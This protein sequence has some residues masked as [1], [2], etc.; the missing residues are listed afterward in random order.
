MLCACVCLGFGFCFTSPILARVCGVCFW[1][2]GFLLAAQWLEC[3]C[4]RLC[5]AYTPPIVAGVLGFFVRVSAYDFFR[6]S[7]L[8]QLPAPAPFPAHAACPCPWGEQG[9]SGLLKHMHSL[10]TACVMFAYSSVLMSVAR[11]SKS[12]QSLYSKC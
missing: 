1:V 10:A 6:C 8:S 4:V 7:S 3:V 2:R 11:P 12:M 9:A 5:S